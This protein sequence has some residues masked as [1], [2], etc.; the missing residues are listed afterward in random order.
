MGRSFQAPFCYNEINDLLSSLKSLEEN[1]V[2]QKSQESDAKLS[3]YHVVDRKE[4]G[5]EL[6]KALRFFGR[7]CV[8][9][10][11]QDDMNSAKTYL[12][13]MADATTDDALL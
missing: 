10:L 5:L 6:V 7:R 1:A 11:S 13:F 3:E 2:H 9:I 12:Q 8:T 4:P